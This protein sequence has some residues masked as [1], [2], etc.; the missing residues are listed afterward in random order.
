MENVLVQLNDKFY[1][2]FGNSVVKNEFG[3]PFVMYHKSRSK[4]N[5]ETFE[6]GGV[7]KNEYNNDY[8]VYF[9][10]DA[11]KD[12]ISYIADGLEFYCFLKIEKPFFIYDYNSK[13]YDMYSNELLYIDLSQNYC[14]KILNLGH[15][16]III[17]SIYYDQYL[18]FNP[19]QIKST[20]NTGEYSTIEDN[21]FL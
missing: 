20:K 8:G 14:E 5:F 3:T 9:V 10:L 11:H 1:E 15:D 2:W 18:V 19:N 21:I 17:R 4:E 16:G 13:P 12:Y 7:H 6:I